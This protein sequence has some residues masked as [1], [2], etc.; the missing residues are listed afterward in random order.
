[1][2]LF[3]K[4]ECDI[5]GGKIG[6]LGNRKLEDG[7][8]CKD[9]AK[10]LSPLF[11]ERRSSTVD[12]IKGQLEYRKQNEMAIKSFSP[13][14]SLGKD[15]EI[16]IDE[17]SGTFIYCQ[18]D[19]WRDHN[20]DIISVSQVTSCILDIKQDEQEIYMTDGD[21]DRKS[22]NPP[23]HKISYEFWMDIQINSPWFDDINYRLDTFEEI[24]NTFDPNFQKYS[25]IGYDICAALGRPMQ[26]ITMGGYQQGMPMQGGYQQG[27]PMQGGYP[28]QPMQGGYPQQ[29]M[30]GGYPQQPM[31][32][33][34]PQQPMQGGYPQQPMQGGYPQQPM[35]RGYPQQPMQGGYP[36]QP[37]QGGY[38]QQ[39]M[40][41]GY[42]QQPM[43]GGYPQQP[44]QGGYQ[45]QPMQGGMKQ[46][47]G[48]VAMPAVC[49]TCQA[50]TE[51]DMNGKCPF[52]GE[53]M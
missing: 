24:E 19:N 43:Q 4:K 53:D 12:E 42:P 6:M 3:D 7:N 5:C 13:T 14:R 20:P 27:M 25:Q 22:Y 30:Q 45:Q 16:Q 35:Q 47:M 38:P 50:T 26:P 11:S 40:Q 37:M 15:G 8:M 18:R 17:R 49:A 1:M 51:P 29:P 31:Q 33:G 34:Y 2:G 36:Q 52:C 28:Q 39:P 9:C 10:E 41:G 44:M 23:R 21:G 32:G 46:P 48:G